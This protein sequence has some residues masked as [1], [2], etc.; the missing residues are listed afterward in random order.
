MKYKGKILFDPGDVTK[1]HSRQG[2]WKKTAM[3]MAKDETPAMWRW[4]LRKRFGLILN[5]PLRGSHITFINDRM[6]DQKVWEKVKKRWNGVT[7]DC[8]LG[9]YITSNGEHWWIPVKSC[10]DILISVRESLSLPS[11]PFF[12]LHLTI[13]Y[14]NER[15]IEHSKYI[16]RSITTRGVV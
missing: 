12:P 6:G 5:P 7:T 10:S 1:K 8:I 9:D 15:N 3:L 4:Y 11:A 16:L 13:G 14:A 2:V